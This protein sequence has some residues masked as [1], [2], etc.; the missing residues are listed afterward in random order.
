MDTS[1]D[2]TIQPIEDSDEE[3]FERLDDETDSDSDEISMPRESRMTGLARREEMLRQRQAAIDAREVAERIRLSGQSEPTGIIRTMLPRRT[4]LRS[5][6]SQGVMSPE[7]NARAMRAQAEFDQVQN[8]L[9]TM[10]IK[11]EAEEAEERRQFEAR[12]KAL[13]DRVDAGIKEEEAKR[14]REEQIRLQRLREE[15]EA[16]EKRLREAKEEQEAKARDAREKEEQQKREQEKRREEEK[17]EEQRV[18]QAEQEEKAK[19]SGSVG[20]NLDREARDAFDAWSKKMVNIKT[21][22]LPVV[23]QNTEWRKQCFTAKRSLTRGVSQLTNSRT[24][25]IRITQSIS[26]VLSQ[27]KGAT[28]N[29][30]I[31]TWMLNHLSKCFIR[32]AEQ[33]VASK[34]DTAFPLARV[35]IW[36][37]LQGHAELSEVLMARLVKKCCWC[38]PYCPGKKAGQDDAAYSKMLGKASLDEAT[39]AYTTRMTGIVAFYFAICQTAPTAPPGSSAVDVKQIPD[40]FRIKALWIWQA[41]AMSPRVLDQSLS[42]ALWSALLEAAGP[43]LLPTYGKQVN[44]V[45]RLMLVEGLGQEKA[46]FCKIQAA[47]SAKVRLKQL[48]EDWSKSGSVQGATGG[49]DM[50]V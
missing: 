9:N 41:R 40:H 4:K 18:K 37:I 34:Q 10:R 39:F 43:T 11:G 30:E 6:P 32:Q 28:P 26:E 13:W 20:A 23:A 33:E 35:V 29:G 14:A 21:N 31:Y 50:E 44:K 45:W 17:A 24:E 47:N 1:G 48:L 42:P 16:E 36:L 22:V 38:L 19:S 15:K 12:N 5:Y 7:A 3:D 8:L 27:A 2:V 46:A 25:I 49:R